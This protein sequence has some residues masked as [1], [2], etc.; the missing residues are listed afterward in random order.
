MTVFNTRARGNTRVYNPHSSHKV[1]VVILAKSVKH[2]RHCVA[3]KSISKKRWIRI[4]SNESG[5]ELDDSHV[6]ITNPHGSFAVKP[7]QKVYVN[8]EKSVPLINQPENWLV[9]SQVK[10]TQ[11]YKIRYA[12]LGEYLDRPQSLW[13]VGDKVNYSQILSGEFRIEQSLYLVVVNRVRLYCREFNGKARRRI[14]FDYNSQTYDLAVTD[15]NFDKLKV[16][17]E[18]LD[19]V[20]LCISL[21]EPSPYDNHCYKIV[22]TIFT[23]DV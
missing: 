20:I 22:A 16:K 12:D 21:G 5:A 8:I 14:E 4:V 19:N 18:T 10:W 15:P 1:E 6:M 2:G 7:L 23:E 3:G 13:G 17:Y 9:D 11:N